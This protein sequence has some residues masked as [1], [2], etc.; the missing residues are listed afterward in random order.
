MSSTAHQRE[1]KDLR[2]AG[3]NPI[4]SAMGGRGASAPQGTMVSPENPLKGVAQSAMAIRH[5]D[6]D[7]KQKNAA[8]NAANSAA[9]LASK[10][11]EG[12]RIQNQK[13]RVTKK[14]YEY[15]DKGVDKAESWFK[16][17]WKN[18][19]KPKPKNKN[20]YY[21]KDGRYYRR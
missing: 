3:L 6:A 16:K 8:A 2:A 14:P 15:L 10:Q 11:A 13:D 19:N 1:V 7:I 17:K 12:K 21:Q 18:R 20:K 5:L 4:L 9:N